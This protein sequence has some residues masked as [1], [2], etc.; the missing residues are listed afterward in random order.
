MN[1]QLDQLVSGHPLIWRGG[2]PLSD[3]CSGMPTGFAELDAVL[4]TGGWPG[5]ALV[6]IVVERFGIGEIS[7]LMSAMAGVT[8][9]GGWLVWVTPP[10]LPYAPALSKSGVDLSR[11]VV[12]NYEKSDRRVLWAMEQV[13]TA[14]ACRMVVGWPHISDE[15]AVRRLQSAAASGDTLGVLFRTHEASTSPAALRLRLSRIDDTLQVTVL[16]ARGGWR[17]DSVLLEL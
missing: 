14:K 15:R 12:L 1:A 3:D 2:A 5:N 6:E 16:K 10:F 9:Q 7:L 17:R 11:L 4:P 13:L 8:Q